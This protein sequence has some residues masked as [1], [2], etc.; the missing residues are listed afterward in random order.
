MG[1]THFNRKYYSWT[2]PTTAED[3]DGSE[4]EDDEETWDLKA[5]DSKVVGREG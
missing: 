3:A 5:P 2:S 4:S 1:F